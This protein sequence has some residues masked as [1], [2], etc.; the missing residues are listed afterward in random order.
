MTVRGRT[1][2]LW[3]DDVEGSGTGVRRREGAKGDKV[4]QD[5]TEWR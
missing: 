4:C 2:R 5:G 3:W 1:R